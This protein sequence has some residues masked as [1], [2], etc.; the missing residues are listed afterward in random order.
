MK[1]FISLIMD[2]KLKWKT[3]YFKNLKI[4][5]KNIKLMKVKILI[6]NLLKV[7]KML[8]IISSMHN[9]L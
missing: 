8:I 1:V 5:K 9:L 2:K 4:I 7:F 6:I 3:N